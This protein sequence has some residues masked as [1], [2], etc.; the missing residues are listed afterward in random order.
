MTA[1]KLENQRNVVKNERRQG[2]ENPP[3][4]RWYKLM[5]ENLFPLGHPYHTD[6]I[7]S[8]EDLS[9]ASMD[10]VMEFFRKY[11]TPNNLSLVVA[12]DFDMA[13][14]KRLIEKYFGS[15]PPGPALE[16]PAKVFQKLDGEKIVEVNDRVP[17][18]RTYFGWTTPGYFDA[19]DAELELTATILT[20]G[21]SA[22][23]NKALIYDKQLASDIVAFQSGQPIGGAFMM[24]ATARPGV[25]LNQIEQIISSE[26]ARLAK[27]GPTAE[28]LNR[29]KTKWEFGFISGL[30]RI[31]GFGGK[32]D[33][34]NQYN[35]FLGDPGKFDQDLVRHRNVTAESLKAAV[36]KYLNTKNRVLV[37]FHPE[38]SVQPSNVAVDRTKIPALGGDK[39]FNAPDVKSAKLE[40]GMEV[41]VV[42][43]PEIPKVAVG[44]VNPR[45]KRCRFE[46][47]SRT[48]GDD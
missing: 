34:L 4:G 6:V 32:S 5:T 16:R 23:L 31:G 29:A 10:D 9:A 14:T 19:G 11:Y 48:R 24:W 46:R 1:E 33:L 37:R 39:P 20:D 45:R 42:E 12:G 7:G 21:L 26:I 17:Q 36:D 25:N 38:K 30:E 22:R 3:Y 40:N 44:I 35:T 43:K 8:Q 47:Q 15:I 13:E 28:E 27:D 18:E 41:F 2:L